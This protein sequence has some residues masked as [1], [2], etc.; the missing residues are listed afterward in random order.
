M[1]VAK[2]EEEAAAITIN[3]AFGLA[4]KATAISSP[5]GA[6]RAQVA[7]FDINCVKTAAITNKTVRMTGS[8][9]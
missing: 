2:E 8:D 4:P 7:V 1:G 5:I 9:V 3:T 6:K